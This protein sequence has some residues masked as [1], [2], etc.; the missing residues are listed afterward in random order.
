M[1]E[2]ALDRKI[3]RNEKEEIFQMQ[4][5]AFWIFC[6]DQIRRENKYPIYNHP[7]TTLHN[8]KYGMRV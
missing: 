7:I 4:Y 2:E 6:L 3:F 1:R 8:N 5:L